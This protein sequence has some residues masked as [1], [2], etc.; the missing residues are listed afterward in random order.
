MQFLYSFTVTSSVS[1]PISMYICKLPISIHFSTLL[2]LYSLYKPV[3]CVSNPAYTL[4]IILPC[5]IYQFSLYP[6]Y[7]CHR[8]WVVMTLRFIICTST[9]YPP[10]LLKAIYHLRS[11]SWEWM[12]MRMGKSVKKKINRINLLGAWATDQSL[13]VTASRVWLLQKF[14]FYRTIRPVSS[15]PFLVYSI[16]TLIGHDICI[17]HLII[18]WGLTV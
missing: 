15:I 7:V 9:H 4:V 13:M 8:L 6:H 17:S 18:S 3:S 2:L 16:L 14:L 1:I 5:T 11:W 10:I 12:V